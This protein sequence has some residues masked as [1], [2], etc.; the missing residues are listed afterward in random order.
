MRHG[1]LGVS[2]PVTVKVGSKPPLDYLRV[3]LLNVYG[4]RGIR[5]AKR[6]HN[7]ELIRDSSVLANKLPPSAV[8]DSGSLTA[9][10]ICLSSRLPHSLSHVYF[11]RGRRPPVPAPTSL[12][13]AINLYL[14]SR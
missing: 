12:F 8:Y 4:S 10:D 2:I 6:K 11:S 13:L 5:L 14:R 7:R 1:D 9:R 3:Y